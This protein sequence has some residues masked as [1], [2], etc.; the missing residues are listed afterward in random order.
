MTAHCCTSQGQH[1]TMTTEMPLVG[2]FVV[3][4]PFV[5]SQTT[6]GSDFTVQQA[7][8]PINHTE[9]AAAVE[10]GIIRECYIGKAKRRETNEDGTQR[11]VAKVQE[12]DSVNRNGRVYPAPILEREIGRMKTE[13]NRRP[14]AVDHPEGFTAGLRTLAL[15]WTALW[16]EG[17]DVWGE[18]EIVPTE[19][20]RDLQVLIDSGLEIGISSRGFGSVKRE[21]RGKEEVLVIQDDFELVT[22]DAVS[23]PS[24]YSARIKQ[25]ESIDNA[26]INPAEIEDTAL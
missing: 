15:K 24:V 7:A 8:Q 18:F 3:P 12:I 4:A 20:G 11:Y 1:H 23:D 21:M 9:S 25:I 14:G 26:P 13:I 10:R 22:F 2:G 16:T 5:F 19:A 6:Y 17:S